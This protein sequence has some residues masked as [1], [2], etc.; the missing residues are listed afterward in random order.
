MRWPSAHS[1]QLRLDGAGVEVRDVGARG[2]RHVPP[3]ADLSGDEHGAS[4]GLLIL[5]REW[6]WPRGGAWRRH[7]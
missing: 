7:P 3:L 6:C 4:L 1:N 2:T 5:T